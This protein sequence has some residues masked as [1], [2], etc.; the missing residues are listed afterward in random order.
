VWKKPIEGLLITS[1]LTL[2]IANLFDLTSISIIGSSGFLIIFTAVNFSN[3]RLAS[4]TKSKRWIA[5]TGG[6][7]CMVAMAILIGQIVVKSPEQLWVLVGLVSVS[8]TVEVIYRK[9][10][11]RTIKPSKQ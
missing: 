6:M 5:I 7:L 8:F 1:I 10:T 4:A 9:V 11:G 3:A 2:I